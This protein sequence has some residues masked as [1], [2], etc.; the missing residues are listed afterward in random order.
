MSRCKRNQVS[1]S[2]FTLVELLVVISIIALL[3]SILLPSLNKAREQAKLL[4]C[5][6]N[7]RQLM[8][9]EMYYAEDHKDK[10]PPAYTAQMYIL[11]GLP[12]PTGEFPTVWIENLDKYIDNETK[13]QAEYRLECS[14]WATWTA[15]FKG[16]G[17]LAGQSYSQN[18]LMDIDQDGSLDQSLLLDGVDVVPGTPMPVLKARQPSEVVILSESNS[19]HI[20]AN[21]PEWYICGPS[22]P[23]NWISPPDYRHKNAGFP[24]AYLDGHASSHRAVE[25]INTITNPPIWAQ[26]PVY[27]PDIPDRWWL[28]R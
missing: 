1:R 8:I 4:L 20:T 28:L 6:N 24:I 11:L 18:N 9:A 27:W 19:F 26:G 15:K 17:T 21:K 14:S 25:H 5:V 3:V 2:G 12:I 23:P 13:G 16:F 22:N 10:L 7:V